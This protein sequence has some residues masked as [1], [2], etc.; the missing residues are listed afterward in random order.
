MRHSI[1]EEIITL[2]D[3]VGD[4]IWSPSNLPPDLKPRIKQWIYNGTIIQISRRRSN[5]ESRYTINQALIIK[6]RAEKILREKT[7]AY[8]SGTLDLRELSTQTGLETK[9]LKRRL[10]QITDKGGIADV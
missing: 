4:N 2:Y 5:T 7:L 6:I 9:Y 8:I 3:I 1:T 10:D